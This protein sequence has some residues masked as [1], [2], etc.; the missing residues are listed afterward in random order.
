MY[1]NTYNYK[2]LS[3]EGLKSDAFGTSNVFE[4]SENVLIKEKSPITD[5]IESNSIN[6]NGI[7]L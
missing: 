6:I 7:K 5:F 2:P 4:I 3:Y 1:K